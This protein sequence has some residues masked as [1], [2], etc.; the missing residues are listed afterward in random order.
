MLKIC[1]I[2]LVLLAFGTASLP[3]F[4]VDGKTLQ[5]G[6]IA[7]LRCAPCHG[8]K[9]GEPQKVGP[10][11]SQTIGTA[12]AG[13]PGF[14]YTEALRKANLT[15]D[16]TTYKRFIANPS[17]LVPGTSMAYANSLSDAEIAALLTFIKSETA[18]Q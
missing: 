16:D 2:I 6:R 7:F 11:L 8:I 4:A 15:W 18:A 13:V 12:A 3:L 1:K 5:R 9:P 14:T 17:A 10:N